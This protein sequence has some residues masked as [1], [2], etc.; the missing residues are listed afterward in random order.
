M[1]LQLIYVKH[2]L[3]NFTLYKSDNLA[4]KY[5]QGHDPPAEVYLQWLQNA[6]SPMLN[7]YE[8]FCVCCMHISM[9]N[10]SS[11]ALESLELYLLDTYRCYRVNIKNDMIKFIHLHYIHVFNTN[12]DVNI[13]GVVKDIQI[14]IYK[15]KII[16]KTN[17]ISI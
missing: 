15:G 16:R 6:K 8:T 17:K 7:K 14:N 13:L 2:C 10:R 9:C 5:L 3:I 4:G 1:Q 11:E 12:R